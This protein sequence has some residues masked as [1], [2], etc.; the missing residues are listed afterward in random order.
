MRNNKIILGDNLE[1]LRSFD[2][3]LVQLAY[4]DPPFSTG[5]TKVS[6]RDSSIR[7]EDSYSDYIGFLLPRLVELRRVLTD[8]GSIFV[9]VDPRESHYVKVL[10]DELFGRECFMN[11][12][13]WLWDYGARSKKKWS[14]KHNTIFW[15]VKDSKHHTFNYDAIDRIPYLAP[16]LCG[17]EKAAR[18]KTPTDCWWQTIVHTRGK[19]RCGYPTQKP[20]KIL[21]RIVRVHSNPGD[22]VLDCFAGSGTTGE[23]AVRNGRSYIMVDSNLQ[24]T[25]IMAKR[26]EFSNPELIGFQCLPEILSPIVGE[27]AMTRV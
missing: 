1:I 4:I 7:F 26:L 11:E 23:A 15:Y 24:A 19:E 18:G 22:T 13:I 21:E 5:V 27:N 3:G 20:L 8:D 6:A 14:V 12:I 9:H 16:N 10:L 25:Q 2:S 17:P